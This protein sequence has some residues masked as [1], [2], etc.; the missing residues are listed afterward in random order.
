MRK[1]LSKNIIFKVPAAINP[2]GIEFFVFF[3]AF[4]ERIPNM[5][6]KTRDHA[7]FL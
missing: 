2:T 4:D 1:F 6:P 3:V 7:Y 5:P